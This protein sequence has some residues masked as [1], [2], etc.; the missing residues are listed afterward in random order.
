[1][2]G[3]V[4]WVWWLDLTTTVD[5][6]MIKAS[7]EKATGDGMDAKPTGERQP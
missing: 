3:G 5:H 2:W 1:M 6:G 7:E 4:T